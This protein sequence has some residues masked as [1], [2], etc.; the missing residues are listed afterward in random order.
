[1]WLRK[2]S[3][4]LFLT[5]VF[6]LATSASCAVW[7]ASGQLQER[8]EQAHLDRLRAVAACVAHS[9]PVE[10]GEEPAPAFSQLVDRLADSVHC[11]ISVLRKAGGVYA[12]SDPNVAQADPSVIRDL[13]LHPELIIA[14]SQGEGHVR[15]KSAPGVPPALHYAYRVRRADGDDAFIRLRQDLQSHEADVASLRRW[16]AGVAA[17]A[18]ALSYPLIHMLVGRVTQPLVELTQ[19]AERLARGDYDHRVATPDAIEVKPLVSAL[20]RLGNQA[21]TREDQL[22]ANLER[23]SAVLTGMIEGV[24]A[25]DRD[26]NILFANPAA[27]KLLDFRAFDVEKRTLMEAARVHP[28]RD[29]VRRVLSKGEPYRREVQWQGPPIRELEIHAMPLPGNPCQGVVVVIDDVTQLRRLESSRQQ[30]IANVSHELK[31]PLSSIKAYTETLL[32]GALNDPP[33]N[34]RFL[35]SIAEQTDR[36]QDLILDMLSLARIES[37]QASVDLRQIPLRRVAERSLAGCA[38]RAE[39]AGVEVELEIDPPDLSLYADEEALREILD[40]LIDNAVKYSADGDIVLVSAERRG[41]DVVIDVI[42][43]GV[44][45]PSEHLGR[46]F[47]RFYR[48][49]KARSRELGGTGLGLSIVKHLCQALGGTVQVASVV[50]EGSTFSVTIPAERGSR[51]EITKS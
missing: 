27:G 4:R 47:E 3:T 2:L 49:D 10:W 35:Q 51:R 44:G 1:M 41:D 9:L 16:I 48:V 14:A 12:T 42:D 46:L 40:N 11:E 8:L 23:R 19:H 22:V 45:I 33:H 26:E 32:N 7:Y 18:A 34:E 30:F 50:G 31:T 38:P 36:L 21:K 29:A 37:G 20:E 24:I 6:A 39:A 25:V 43:R 17:L 5:L 13:L 28:I 15:R